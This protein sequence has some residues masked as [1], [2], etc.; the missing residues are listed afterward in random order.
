M[1]EKEA[2]LAEMRR[3]ADAAEAERARTEEEHGREIARLS[4]EVE[5]LMRREKEF[6]E[7]EKLLRVQMAEVGTEHAEALAAIETAAESSRRL[8]AEDA[9]NR[10]RREREE[11]RKE[12]QRNWEE[13]RE[14]D[15]SEIVELRAKISSLEAEIKEGVMKAHEN[16]QRMTKL[17]IENEVMSRDLERESAARSDAEEQLSTLS[18]VQ[19]RCT[20]LQCDRDLARSQ[21]GDHSEMA[22]ELQDYKMQV[23]TMSARVEHYQEAVSIREKQRDESSEQ[24]KLLQAELA[25]L[26]NE[27]QKSS[28]VSAREMQHLRD[29]MNEMKLKYTSERADREAQHREKLGALRS[30]L[31]SLHGNMRQV[32][33]E[34][35]DFRVQVEVARSAEQVAKADA[36]DQREKVARAVSAEEEAKRQARAEIEIAKEE[37]AQLASSAS[38]EKIATAERLKLRAIQQ[39]EEARASLSKVQTLNEELKA[40]LILAKEEAHVQA[41]QIDKLRNV[42][43]L[44]ARQAKYCAERL[45]EIEAQERDEKCS[46]TCPLGHACVAE[47]IIPEPCAEDVQRC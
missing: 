2:T 29:I 26:R 45:D 34:R 20:Q 32:E 46:G 18:A 19:D 4:A 43:R 23:N 39:C 25:A 1:A 24:C 9:E 12:V 5:A 22:K 11:V 8:M 47:T 30:E 42:A 41:R 10:V 38:Q 15:R 6:R 31:Q 44:A 7:N 36:A 28:Q 35:D 14:R 3:R 27:T 37:A 17:A 40:E 16:E 33:A 13:R 21:L